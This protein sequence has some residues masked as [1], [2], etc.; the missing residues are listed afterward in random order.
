MAGRS[1]SQ[2]PLCIQELFSTLSALFAGVSLSLTWSQLKFEAISCLKTTQNQ[3]FADE[4]TEG[5]RWEVPLPTRS[6][7]SRYQEG[8][9][10]PL[11]D[12]SS[13]PSSV[14]VEWFQWLDAA[15]PGCWVSFC[16]Q[17]TNLNI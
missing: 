16:G 9:Q 11:S 4:E 2:H 7:G 3:P 14:P 10:E 8:W 6:L 12:F 5:Q 15:Q 17:I 13:S 1:N